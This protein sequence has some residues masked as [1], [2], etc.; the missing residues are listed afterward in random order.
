M[1]VTPRSMIAPGVARGEWWHRLDDGRIQC[2]LCPRVCKLRE[3]Q[4][5]FCFI[6]QRRGDAMVLTS[7][8]RASG[9]C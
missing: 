6:R 3:G 1:P 7:Y 4:R 9:F 2:D 5:G 8:G